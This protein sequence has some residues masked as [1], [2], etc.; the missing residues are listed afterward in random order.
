MV[1]AA[2]HRRSP[3]VVTRA[4]LRAGALAAVAAGGALG[5]VLR[6]AATYAVPDGSGFPWTTLAIN[7][8]GSLA[9]AL[10]PA[11]VAIR[12]RQLLSLALGPGV[13]GGFTTFS[14]YAEQGRGLLGDGPPVVALAYLLGTV[15]A[16]LV[17]VHVGRR[18]TSG[19]AADDEV[20]A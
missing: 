9:L 20:D 8:V 17:A 11:V 1:L 18:L 19:P 16:C 10:L 12:R 5:A 3:R 13:L 7:V 6:W 4:P 15:A 14:A 2:A